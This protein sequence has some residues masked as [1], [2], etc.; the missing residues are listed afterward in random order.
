[1]ER[2]HGLFEKEAFVERTKAIAEPISKATK[3]K[4]AFSLFGGGDTTSVIQKT[5]HAE[6]TSFVSTGGGTLLEYM[7]GKELPG[8]T[9]IKEK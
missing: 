8:I 2:A 4:K 5:K 7:E 1:M 3:E 9:A 6:A